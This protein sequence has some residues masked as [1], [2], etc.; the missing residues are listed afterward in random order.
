MQNSHWRTTRHHAMPC[1]HSFYRSI[2]RCVVM[3]FHPWCLLQSV[4][5][6]SLMQFTQTQ[7]KRKKSH[8][9]AAET[10]N[11]GGK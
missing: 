9:Y 3:K 2:M 7:R 8:E 11:E 4:K 5:D 6:P 1:F 10:E